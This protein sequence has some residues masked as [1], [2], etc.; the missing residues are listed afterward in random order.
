[1]TDNK[2]FSVQMLRFR[3]HSF[4]SLELQE[5]IGRRKKNR[6]ISLGNTERHDN[7]CSRH[8]NLASVIVWRPGLRHTHMFHYRL[9]CKRFSPNLHNHVCERILVF[10]RDVSSLIF[11]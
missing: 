1:M 2:D 3:W 6:L 4:F 10:A 7:N 9:K 11:F 8:G 5:D